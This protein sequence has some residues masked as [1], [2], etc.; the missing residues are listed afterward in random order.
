MSPEWNREVMDK[1]VTMVSGDEENELMCVMSAHTDESSW[2]AGPW[3]KLI[4]E[5]GWRV[6][7]RAVYRLFKEKKEGGRAR[8]KHL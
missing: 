7:E 3:R 8:V 1:I 2:S 6:T 4:P 5:T